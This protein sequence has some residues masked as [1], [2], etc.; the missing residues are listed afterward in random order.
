MAIKS[1]NTLAHPLH[2]LLL[3]RAFPSVYYDSTSYSQSDVRIFKIVEFI[4]TATIFLRFDYYSKKGNFCIMDTC[5]INTYLMDTCIM[6]TCL[7][8]TYIMETC[9]MD[10]CI[11]DSCIR[12]IYNGYMYHEC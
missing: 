12:G 7:M 1:K 4:E 2:D 9:I 8:D 6:D 5:I 3:R 10:T 11:M